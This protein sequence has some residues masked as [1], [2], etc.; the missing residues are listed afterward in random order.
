MTAKHAEHATVD[1]STT[2]MTFTG[3]DAFS[4]NWP[5]G[6]PININGAH[7]Q[8]AFPVTPSALT[9]SCEQACPPCLVVLNSGL[10]FN[11]P[12][13]FLGLAIGVAVTAIAAA[14]ALRGLRREDD[15]RFT[16]SRGRRA[17]G[18]GV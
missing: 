16:S 8:I 18:S 1:W 3:G 14:H 11:L 15:K 10:S 12:C 2:G 4:P 5:V 9:I 17:S 6:T 13:F 7:C